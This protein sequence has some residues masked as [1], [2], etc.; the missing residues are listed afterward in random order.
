MKLCP[1]GLCLESQNRVAN[2]NIQ[3]NLRNNPFLKNGSLQA[4]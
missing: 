2:L 4:R 1:R 3:Q